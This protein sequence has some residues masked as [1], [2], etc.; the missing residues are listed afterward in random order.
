[1]SMYAYDRLLYPVV[2]HIVTIFEIQYK[3]GRY[4]DILAVF[5]YKINLGII[6]RYDI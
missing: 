1:M 5:I 2:H 6:I 4:K 3:A